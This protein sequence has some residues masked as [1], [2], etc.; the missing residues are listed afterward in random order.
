MVVVEEQIGGSVYGAEV[1]ST[2]V[3]V[4]VNGF[5]QNG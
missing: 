4:V 1:S 5:Y 3:D 2:N